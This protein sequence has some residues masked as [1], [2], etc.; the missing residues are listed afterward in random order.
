MGVEDQQMSAIIEYFIA[1]C[2]PDHDRQVTGD[3]TWN[4]TIDLLF[5]SGICV[6]VGYHIIGYFWNILLLK[7]LNVPPLLLIDR[8]A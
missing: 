8:T 5:F 3:P 1:Q 6:C 4:E 2:S 7:P